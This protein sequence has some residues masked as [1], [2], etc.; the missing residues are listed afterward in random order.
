[1]LTLNNHINTFNDIWKEVLNNQHNSRF[2]SIPLEIKENEKEIE[3][4]L[5]VPGIHKSNIDISYHNDILSITTKKEEVK[6]N[7]N[8][9][10]SKK[11]LFTELQNTSKE[12]KIKLGNDI[13]VK[14]IRSE[15][16]NGVLEIVI[17]KKE[18]E[19]P[20]RITIN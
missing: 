7:S 10:K 4:T 16:K 12:R 17:Q 8:S 14:D 6:E 11:I 15:L 18:K 20:K 5:E 1:M 13:D 2:S 3:L 19:Q 9:K